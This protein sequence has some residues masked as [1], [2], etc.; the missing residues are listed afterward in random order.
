MPLWANHQVKESK[1][2]ILSYGL[3]ISVNKRK[4]VDFGLISNKILSHFDLNQDVFYAEIHWSTV[5]ELMVMNK[6]GI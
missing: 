3:S 6:M 4:V 5:L 1:S 2:S